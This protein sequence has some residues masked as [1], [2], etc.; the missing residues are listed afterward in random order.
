MHTLKQKKSSF[1]YVFLYQFSKFERIFKIQW[2]IQK[3]W[4]KTIVNSYGILWQASTRLIKV[5]ASGRGWIPS[6]KMGLPFSR[7]NGLTVLE[8]TSVAQD[9]MCSIIKVKQRQAH[10][11]C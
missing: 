6:E 2:R 3:L 8:Q 9:N 4:P 5:V 1:L 11:L 10:A 7:K